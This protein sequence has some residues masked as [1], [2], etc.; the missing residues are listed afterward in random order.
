MKKIITILSVFVLLLICTVSVSANSIDVPEQE[1]PYNSVAEMPFPTNSILG[2]AILLETVKV[3]GQPFNGQYYNLYRYEVPIYCLVDLCSGSSYMNLTVGSSNSITYYEENSETTTFTQQIAE[4]NS[5]SLTG[6][7]GTKIGFPGAEME[8]SISENIQ[9]S[10]TASYGNE[11][12]YSTTQGYS[13]T[14]NYNI[15]ESGR[16]R[17]ERRAF[18]YVYVIQSYTIV[19]SSGSGGINPFAIR[20]IKYY[21]HNNSI[22]LGL[23]ENGQCEVGLVKYNL[24]NGAYVVDKQYYANVFND[25]NDNFL[26]L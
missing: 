16:Y 25:G 19:S 26:V 18:L 2:D 14:I 9:T 17:L 1:T 12:S 24:V 15:L 13:E 6:S 22:R 21:F 3:S 11:F 8:T 5:L 4:I 20:E 23:A 10:L 7:L